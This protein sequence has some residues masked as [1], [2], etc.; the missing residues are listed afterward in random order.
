MKR[1]I[2]ASC[3]ATAA[4]QATEE[5]SGVAQAIEECPKGGNYPNATLP[6]MKLW[7]PQT[8]TPTPQPG[9][10][11]IDFVD[12]RKAG[13]HL[14][15]VVDPGQGLITWGVVVK[16]S[17]VPAYRATRSGVQPHIGD[18]CRPPPP[19]PGGDDWLARFTLESGRIIL[20]SGERASGYAD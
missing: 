7:T 16:D 8:Q 18:C 11:Y 19:P 4:C 14:A 10:L 20:E 3:V 15:F 13:Q 5:T 9:Q 17:D 12:W 1:W 2:I 6:Q